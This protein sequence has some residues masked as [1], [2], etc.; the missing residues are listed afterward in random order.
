MKNLLI[1]LLLVSGHL[2]SI[3]QPVKTHGQLKVVGTQL[4]DM[5]GKPV[6]LR[7]VSFG[8][9][10]W[11]PRFYNA[12]TVKWLYDD[13]KCTVVRAAMGVEPDKGY[14]KDPAGSVA[15]VKAVVDGAIRS[16]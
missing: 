6:V 5:N 16:G 1:I 3:A 7:G 13:W 8:W 9:H 10:N 11:W 15:K 2:F 14:I 12:G 4:Q